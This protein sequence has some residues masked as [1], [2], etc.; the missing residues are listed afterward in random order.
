[1]QELRKTVNRH[2]RTI[3]RWMLE[4]NFPKVTRINGRVYV[5]EDEFEAWIATKNG[6]AA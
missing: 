6:D 2:R 4:P 3:G 5:Y 1:M